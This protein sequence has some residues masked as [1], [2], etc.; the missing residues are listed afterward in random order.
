MTFAFVRPTADDVERLAALKSE[1]FI[2]TFG[3]DNDPDELAA[4][5]ERK[6]SIPAVAAQLVDPDCETTWVLDQT[7]PVGYLKLNHRRAQTEPGLEQGLEIEQLYVRRSHHGKGLG[8]QLL[9]LAARTAR[10]DGYA[11]L[12]LS[13]WE[14]NG[15]AI[16]LYR[17]RG[18]RVFDEHVFM[19]GAEAQTDLLM[20]LDLQT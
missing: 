4:H 13:V 15:N 1:T 18:Y 11:F 8:G 19:L 9:D 10:R 17:H 12:W 6:F 14:R 2:D 3:A 20:R 7:E 5:V 16:A